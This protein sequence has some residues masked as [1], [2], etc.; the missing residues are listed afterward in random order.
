MPEEFEEP[1][2]TEQFRATEHRKGWLTDEKGRDQVLTIQGDDVE[3]K[4]CHKGTQLSGF[5]SAEQGGEKEQGT[6]RR[7][8]RCFLVTNL[9]LNLRSYPFSPFLMAVL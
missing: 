6:E 1:T 5:P 8:V 3:V 4:W 2:E 7:N 9:P